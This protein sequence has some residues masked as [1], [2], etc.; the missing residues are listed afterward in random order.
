V[1]YRADVP[2]RLDSSEERTCLSFIDQKLL[3]VRNRVSVAKGIE[4]VL[5]VH[6]VL[7]F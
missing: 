2:S 7:S 1:R 3:R 5:I 6:A 4:Q